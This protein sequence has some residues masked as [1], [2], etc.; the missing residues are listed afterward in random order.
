MQ[1]SPGIIMTIFSKIEELLVSFRFWKKSEERKGKVNQFLLGYRETVC[2]LK[3]HKKLIVVTIICTFLQRF[4]VFVLTYVVYRG[5]GLDGF[6]MIDI[7][8]LQASVYIAVD[9]LPVP[10]A[11]GITEVMYKK[12]FRETLINSCKH[13]TAIY[14]KI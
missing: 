12:I 14:G 5:L 2:F 13:F 10:G 6:A 9:M 11:Q 4:S 7:V 1:F 3:N 8:L